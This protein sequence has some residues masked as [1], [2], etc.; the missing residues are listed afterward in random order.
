MDTRRNYCHFEYLTAFEVG[1]WLGISTDE[2]LGR[3]EDGEIPEPVSTK[4]LRWL[5]PHLS[6][7]VR[8]T[9]PQWLAW[10]ANSEQRT[11]WLALQQTEG[12]K[13]DEN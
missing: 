3:W 5:E 6:E 2:V 13:N 11:R 10:W 8:T 4:P 7:W 9:D 1:H 12:T